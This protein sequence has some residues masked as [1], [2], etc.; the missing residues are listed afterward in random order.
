MYQK[1]ISQALTGDDVEVWVCK[2]VGV[3]N[4]LP[5]EQVDDILDTL[6]VE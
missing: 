1:Y 6:K 2:D 5:S 4:R 3:F